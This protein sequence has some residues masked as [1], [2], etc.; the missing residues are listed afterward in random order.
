MSTR[1]KII[2][3]IAIIVLFIFICLCSKEPIK[4]PENSV[5]VKKQIIADKGNRATGELVIV[6]KGNSQKTFYID[7]YKTDAWDEDYDFTTL[8]KHEY[9][10]LDTP[11]SKGWNHVNID[12]PNPTYNIAY[13]KYKITISG[14]GEYVIIDYRDDDYH[15]SS[16]DY[17]RF[18]IWLT[19]QKNETWTVQTHRDT[20]NNVTSG[21]YTVWGLLKD[22]EDPEPDE[23]D[24]D[25]V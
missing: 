16:E 12:N 1:Q 4:A 18:D 19:W 21:N 15:G 8:W 24:F 2:I 22:G 23:T 9:A 17:Y 6:N 10:T 20:I 11:E 5:G 3:L 14:Q 25:K 13:A 7:I